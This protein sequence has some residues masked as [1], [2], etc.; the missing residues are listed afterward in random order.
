MIPSA[1]INLNHN[2]LASV[3][4]ET[5]GL[6]AGYHEIIQIAIVPLDSDVKPSEVMR[7]FYIN[8]RPEHP[9]RQKGAVHVHA[10]SKDVVNN[11]VSQEKASDLL[12]EWFNGL[13][14]PFGKKL[15]PLAHNWGFERGFLTH[16]L[17]LATFDSMFHPYARDTMCMGTMIN[18]AAAW[19][20][21]DCPFRRLSLTSMCEVFGFDILN[22]HDA[23]A[24]ALACAR[25]YREMLRSFARK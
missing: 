9:G 15:A 3:D 19:H 4:V 22:A 13:D 18:D 16:W 17:G 11:A 14:L 25:L 5:T 7:P 2:V 8:I 12:D 23:L 1:L 21:R 6:M 10:I 20:G 24:D